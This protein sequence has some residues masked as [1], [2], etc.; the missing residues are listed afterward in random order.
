MSAAQSRLDRVLATPSVQRVIL[1]VLRFTLAAAFLSA[2][3]DR[4]GLWGPPGMEGVAWGDYPAFLAYT[5]VLLAGL[6]RGLSDVLGGLATVLEIALALA[7][8]L[9]FRLR[10]AAVGSAV[11]LGSFALAML[12]S[13]GPKAVLDYSVLTALAAALALAASSSEAGPEREPDASQI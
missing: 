13:L 9:G 8:T 2:V 3:A 6:P 12:L 5:H 11:L 10:W 1:L 4:L 7:L